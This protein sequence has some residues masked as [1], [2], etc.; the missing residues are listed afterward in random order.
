MPTAH[1]LDDL[2]CR[3]QDNAI[4]WEEIGWPGIEGE[5]FRIHLGYSTGF[6]KIHR[7]ITRGY[8]TGELERWVLHRFWPLCDDKG[9]AKLRLLGG[10]DRG[11]IRLPRI[12]HA[13]LK[14]CI[15]HQW[16]GK[17]HPG[18]TNWFQDFHLRRGLKYPPFISR[19]GVCPREPRERRYNSH[20]GKSATGF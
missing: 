11:A 6:L 10:T 5:D 4:G 3:L 17:P 18:D 9:G 20:S 1:T 19:A 13:L 15:F 14:W 12:A 2:L 7:I 16:Y 8:A